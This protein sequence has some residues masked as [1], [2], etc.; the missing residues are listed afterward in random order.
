MDPSPPPDSDVA[1]IIYNF[2]SR[3]RALRMERCGGRDQVVRQI[4]ARGWR[5]YEAPLPVVLSRLIASSPTVFLDIGAN[6]GFYSL[7]AVLAGASEV[8]AFEPI[9]FI[10]ELFCRNVTHS[11]AGEAAPITLYRQAVAEREGMA[12]IF[13]PDQE[14]G[15]I[16][17]SASLNA[18]F[19]SSHSEVLQVPL[20]TVDR[21]LQ[22]HPLPAA[23]LLV[24]KIDV[25][26]CEQ[27]V[28]AG[29]GD[30]IANHRPLIIT[31]ILPG[32]DLNFY[33][34]FLQEQGYAHHALV[35]P[36]ELIAMEQIVASDFIRDHLLV[37]ME[38]ELEALM[39]K[40]TARG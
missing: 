1:Q 16:E 11:F 14:H 19:R 36:A 21:H 22:E 15:L 28:L 4:E 31:E 2:R 3:R 18:G 8:R 7:L 17:T 24:I 6:S 26:S 38:L 39:S 23:H 13:M 27:Q 9:P 10:S 37:P 30:T 20:T 35:P 34:R 29:A 32:A 5:S 12:E 33:Q 25:E 40:A